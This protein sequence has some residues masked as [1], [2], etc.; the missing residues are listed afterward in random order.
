VAWLDRSRFIARSRPLRTALSFFGAFIIVYNELKNDFMG[1]Q[2]L[3][4][5]GINCEVGGISPLVSTSVEKC[6]NFF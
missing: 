5:G 6:H 1:R 2:E 4:F 3:G